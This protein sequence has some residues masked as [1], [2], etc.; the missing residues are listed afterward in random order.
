MNICHA[1]R[2]H[3][4]NNITA[5][6][7]VTEYGAA[8]LGHAENLGAFVIDA[9]FTAALPSSSE[10]QRLPGRQHRRLLC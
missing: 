10:S 6:T 3:G 1:F 8:A 2:R 4:G 5:K 9:A 7:Q